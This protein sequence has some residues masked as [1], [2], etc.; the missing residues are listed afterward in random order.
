MMQVRER[1]GFFHVGT[2][3]GE[4]GVHEG[5]VE[6]KGIFDSTL[7]RFGFSLLLLHRLQ[8]ERSEREVGD[9]CFKVKTKIH[10]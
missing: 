2:N 3:L 8:E 6:G 10:R 7:V 9:R 5:E 4:N 1:M